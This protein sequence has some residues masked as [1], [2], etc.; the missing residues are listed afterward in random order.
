MLKN[1]GYADNYTNYCQSVWGLS[2]LPTLCLQVAKVVLAKLGMGWVK[3]VAQCF[4]FNK[5]CTNGKECGV[6]RD[7]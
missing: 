3:P 7:E 6:M 4:V 1:S 5:S 2:C